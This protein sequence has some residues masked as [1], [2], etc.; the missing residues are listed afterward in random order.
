M[1]ALLSTLDAKVLGF[2]L[3]KDLYSSDHDFSDVYQSCEKST[4]GKYFRHEGYLFKEN[5][6]CL[7]DCSL[8]ELLVNTIVCAELFFREIVRLHGIPRRK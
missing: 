5:K 1:Y 4:F 8:R 7:R 3:I 6:L 2:E